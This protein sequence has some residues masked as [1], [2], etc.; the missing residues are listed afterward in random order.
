MP[1]LSL[2][3]RYQAFP[4]MICL[5]TSDLHTVETLLNGMKFKSGVCAISYGQQ[6]KICLYYQSLQKYGNVLTFKELHLKI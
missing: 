5:S 2:F 1:S 3:S 6:K 4:K